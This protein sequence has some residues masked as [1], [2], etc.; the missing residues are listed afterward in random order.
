MAHDFLERF[1]ADGQKCFQKREGEH[2]EVH[3]DAIDAFDKPDRLLVSWANRASHTFDLALS[4]A[5]KLIDICEKALEF[6]KCSSCSRALVRE[7]GEPVESMPMQAN[8]L[9]IREG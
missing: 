5:T 8:P 2:Y 9:A 1:V 3:T 4:E 6:F 7:R